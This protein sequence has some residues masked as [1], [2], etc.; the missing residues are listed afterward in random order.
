MISSDAVKARIPLFAKI[1]GASFLVVLV[2][3]G[4]I[5]A[6]ARRD[7]RMDLQD[8]FGLTLQHIAQ[9]AAVF[10]DGDA[11]E[12][13]HQNADAN[14]ADFKMLRDQ[15]ERVRRENKLKED[16]VYTL[17]PRADGMLEFVVMLQ[18]KTFIGDTYKPP[19]GPAERVRWTLQEGAPHYTE[20]YTDQNGSYVSGYAPIRNHDGKV[21]ALLEVDYGVRQYIDELDAQMKRRMWIVPASLLLA[22]LLSVVVARSI[23]A[24]V[25]R[26]VD[27]TNHVRDGHYDRKVDIQT[28]DE[29]HTLADSFN[30]MLGGLRERFAMLKFV[31]RHTRAVIARSVNEGGDLGFRAQKRDVAVFFSDIRGFTPLSDRLAPDRIIAMLNIYLRKEAEIIER[32][33]GAVDKYIGDAVMALFE[34]P[35]R[36]ADAVASAVEVQ[37]ALAKLNA[38][39]AFDEPVEVGI[40]IAGGEVVMGA[41]GYE[42]RLEFAVIG[43]LV[44]LASR[45][46]SV[47]RGGE[48]VISE[49]AAESL[50]ERHAVER[51]EGLK[52]KGFA[53]AVTCFKIKRSAE[54]AA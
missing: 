32:N 21:V 5:A 41:V 42:D 26:L 9:T 14:S 23:T 16:Q 44:N 31:P 7:Q 30:H 15:L 52:L 25:A 33:N 8:K 47:A 18:E 22:I 43:R 24:A 38:E 39:G 46:C 45:L 37:A 35:N 29:L 53:D 17:R 19:P 3:L 40:G 36:F 12:R 49:Q 54:E 48:I 6:V 11:H 50:G 1:S 27:G 10:I 2:V 13:I 4:F 20:I 34:G 51:V 28:R